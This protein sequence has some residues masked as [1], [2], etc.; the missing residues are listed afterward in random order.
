MPNV[1]VPPS[2]KSSSSAPSSPLRP[3]SNNAPLRLIAIA[4]AIGTLVGAFIALHGTTRHRAL[5]AASFG[6]AGLVTNEYAYFNPTS[7]AAKLSPDWEVTNGS[8]FA[9]DGA[10]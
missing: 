6:R 10:G 8:L 1:L 9:H 7:L 5:F 3:R 4:V 2:A